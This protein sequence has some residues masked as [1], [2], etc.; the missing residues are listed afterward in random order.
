L[1]PNNQG[2]RG[3]CLKTVKHRYRRQRSVGGRAMSEITRKDVLEAMAQVGS[4]PSKWPHRSRSTSYDVLHPKSGARFPPKLILSVA[5]QI[6]TGRGLS[7]RAFGG[8]IA[9]N[10]LL[11]Q[12]GFRIVPKRWIGPFQLRQLLDGCLDEWPPKPPLSRSGYLVTKKPWT[13]H[14]TVESIPLYVG[15]T[16]LMNPLIFRLCR[17]DRRR[18]GGRAGG[19]RIVPSA[20]A[21]GCPA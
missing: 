11:E 14:P 6:A 5:S 12:L 4:D 17:R 20:G 9:T 19:W 16:T 21:G 15:G 3:C 8:G 2:I 18:L 10:R 1:K 13:D 7:R